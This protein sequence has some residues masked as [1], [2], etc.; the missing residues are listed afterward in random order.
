[1]EPNQL[2]EWIKAHK[3][4]PSAL[5]ITLGVSRSLVYMWIWGQREIPLWLPLALAQLDQGEP[6]HG[7]R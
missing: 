4:Y 3:M 1:M 6:H 5:A 7:K 2:K